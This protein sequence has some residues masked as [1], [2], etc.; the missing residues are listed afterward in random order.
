VSTAHAIQKDLQVA[1]RRANLADDRELAG[2]VRD[3]GRRF[4]F[5]LNGL[6]QTSRLYRAD[7][8]VFEKPAGETSHLL[9]DLLALLG[10]VHL[11][12]V[13][14]QIYVNDVRLRL[15]QAEQEVVDHLIEELA[16]HDVGGIS[17]HAPLDLS[18]IKLLVRAV[19][20]APAEGSLRR[21]ALASRIGGGGSVQL[22]GRY[23]FRVQGEEAQAKRDHSQILGE[24]G[25]VL[26]EAVANL[27]AQRLPNPLPVRRAVI[28]LVDSVRENPGRGAAE[29]FMRHALGSP[30]QHLLSVTS[31]SILLGQTLGLPAGALSD[32]GVAAM[33]HDVGYAVTAEKDRH[34]TAGA[35]MLLAQRGFHEAKV[36]RLLVALE[37][38]LD[39]TEASDVSRP[40]LFARILRI[41]DDYDWLV[42]PRNDSD[43]PVPPPVAQAMLWAARGTYYDP[44]LLA[45]FVQT[46]GLYPAGSLIEVSGGRRAVSVSSG[47]GREQY[48]L[49]VVQLLD[50]AGTALDDGLV[51]L[52]EQRDHLRPR[53]VLNAGTLD[54][55]IPAALASAFAAGWTG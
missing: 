1:L 52:F 30:E 50:D 37:H 23:R 5:L 48:G 55:D 27:A 13:E 43:P 25:D 20:D 14:D 47:R 29:P 31:V 54:V 35:R 4:V 6:L 8:N 22:S 26:L 19:A 40:S 2:R 36:R 39:D 10:A 16:R 42:A 53:R 41:A 21:A 18:Q 7:N 45:L 44:D 15:S 11:V 9:E 28:D 3:D 32:L 46:M 49:P 51:D 12:C 38:H 24:A 34:G 17:F 33:L